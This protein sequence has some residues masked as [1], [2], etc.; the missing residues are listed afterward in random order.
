M[1]KIFRLALSSHRR[2]RWALCLILWLLRQLRD[3]E[4]N[5]ARRRSDFLDSLEWMPDDSASRCRYA[6][7]EEK[8]CSCEHA[9]DTIESAIAD[10]EFAY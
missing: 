7:A 10:L 5:D 8:Y 6:N 9:C 3:A 2:R 1:Q 4:K